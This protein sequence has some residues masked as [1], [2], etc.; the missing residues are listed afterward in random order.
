MSCELA[1]LECKEEYEC[2]CQPCV[3]AFEVDVFQFFGSS[4][5]GT[6]NYQGCEKME[7]C[8]IVEQTRVVEFHLVD[9]LERDNAFVE[10]IIHLSDRDVVLT[11]EPLDEPYTY[12][13]S[14]SG[15]YEG[16]GIM[17]M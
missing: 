9:N 7:L 14:W 12:S 15:N 16:V 11:A 4:S 2:Y 13:F 10:V 1:G 3:K 5:N 8:G 17:E 6:E